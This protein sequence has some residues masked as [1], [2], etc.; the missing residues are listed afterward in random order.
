MSTLYR[1]DSSVRAGRSVTREIA[2]EVERAWSAERPDGEVVRR[3]LLETPLSPALWMDSL[4]ALENGTP[5][6]AATELAEELLGADAILIAAPLYNWGPSPHI[7]CWVDMLWTEPRF[8]PHR[9]P[10]AGRPIALVTARGG[11][12]SPGSPQEGWDVS[13]PYLARTFGPEVFGGEVTL[14]E[15]ELTLADENPR[16]AHLREQAAALR[17]RNRALA[18]E[19]GAAL[20]RCAARA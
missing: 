11:G 17:E 5:S 12:A 2:D 20:G 4:A 18:R 9:Y 6:A 15:T 14:I 7:T 13:V 16:M 1:V 10:L 8:G 3:D 19:T